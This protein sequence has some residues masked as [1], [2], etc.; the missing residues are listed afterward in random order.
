MKKEKKRKRDRDSAIY[1][2]LDPVKL[3]DWE[4]AK[5]SCTRLST[6]IVEHMILA[7]F[8]VSC[9][10]HKFKLCLKKKM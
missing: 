6:C 3:K 9:F 4:L 7:V 2:S 5:S 10:A 1:T 8:S